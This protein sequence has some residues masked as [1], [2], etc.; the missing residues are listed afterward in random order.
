MAATGHSWLSR[1]VTDATCD[2]VG[3]REDTCQN[4]GEKKREVIPAKGHDW[5]SNGTIKTEPTCTKAGEMEYVCN[6]CKKTKT[7][8]IPA[9]GHSGDLGEITKVRPVRRRA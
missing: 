2:A 5:A 3:E 4:C 6:I 8:P 1:T 9:N 7:E